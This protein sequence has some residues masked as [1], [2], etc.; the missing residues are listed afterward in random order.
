M[1]VRVR[2]FPDAVLRS[3]WRL[4][5]AAAAMNGNAI[6]NTLT[7]SGVV[8]AAH[9][10]ASGAVVVHVDIHADRPAAD[11]AVLDVRLRP[12]GGIE[13][14]FDRL[15][16]IRTQHGHPGKHGVTPDAP[17]AQLPIFPDAAS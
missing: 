11:R 6:F 14:Q 15:A 17:N 9:A 2:P 1:Q 5:A 16:A 4:R 13:Q 7:A 12:G 8:L 3:V 10:R